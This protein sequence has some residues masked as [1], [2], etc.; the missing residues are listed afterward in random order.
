MSKQIE[1]FVLGLIAELKSNLSASYPFLMMERTRRID[2]LD[3]IA[4]DPEIPISE[5]YRKAM[6]ALLIEAEYGYTIETYQETIS[7][8]GQ[9]LLANIFRLGRLSLFYQ[10]LDQK[11]CGFFNVATN[12]WQP[13]P[14]SDNLS[15]RTA[16]DIAA[17]RKPVELLTLPVGRLVV[18]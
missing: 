5:K 2:K 14:Q 12:S 16:V 15:I 11:Q 4:T 18:R 13:L 17:K 3:Q 9:A 8:N 7:L 1:P 10:S 6:E